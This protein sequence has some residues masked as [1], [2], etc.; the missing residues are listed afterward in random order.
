MIYWVRYTTC[1]LLSYI[2]MAVALSCIN[3]Y[4]LLY[5]ESPEFM[6]AIYL[7]LVVI[8]GIGSASS[9]QFRLEIGSLGKKRKIGEYMFFFLSFFKQCFFFNKK[10]KECGIFSFK[11]INA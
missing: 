3:I 9:I 5:D 4:Y 1:F 7:S 8:L 11:I 10:I 6:D 2:D